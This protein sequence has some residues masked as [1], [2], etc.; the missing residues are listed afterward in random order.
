MA[1][2]RHWYYVYDIVSGKVTRINEIKG[3]GKELFKKF[4]VSPDN[5]L[6]AF[7]GKDGYIALVS[8]KVNIC[9]ASCIVLIN[10]LVIDEAMGRRPQDEWECN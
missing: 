2:D 10:A 8:N 3:H 4:T 9:S 6:L 7:L 5:K 1:A